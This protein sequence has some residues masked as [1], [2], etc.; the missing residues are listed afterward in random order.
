MGLHSPATGAFEVVVAA[1]AESVVV[2]PRG[3]LDLATSDRLAATLRTVDAS[4]GVVVL[5]LSGLSFLDAAGLK[6]LIEARQALGE[7]LTVLPGPPPVQRLIALT[8][9]DQAL[10]L[11][12]GPD[13]DDSRAAAAN[14]SYMRELWEAYRAGGARALAERMPGST[15]CDDRPGWGA[16]ELSA[17]WAHTLVPVP[18]PGASYWVQPVGRS[19]FVSA[20]TLPPAERSGVIWS[21]YVFE[22]RTFIRALSLRP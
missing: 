17:F 14:M 13:E 1:D 11:A 21:L 7:R 2:R 9:T 15:P 8:R 4:A 12:P 22:G 19:V 18:D 20:D 10:G 5:D 3:E 6:V 16:G